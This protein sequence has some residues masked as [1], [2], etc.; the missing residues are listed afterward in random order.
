MQT[1]P[2]IAQFWRTASRGDWVAMGAIL[3]LAAIA[4]LWILTLP[5][6]SAAVFVAPAGM[7]AM[8]MHASQWPA[9][10]TLATFAM[11]T[12]MMG[13]MMLPAVAPI[14]LLH[15]RMATANRMQDAVAP[16][17]SLLTLGYASVWVGFALLA[18][19][20]Q[21]AL[22]HAALLNPAD[23]LANRRLA[24]GMLAIA[25]AYQFAPLKQSCLRLCRSP[26]S[27]LMRYYR[28]GSSGAL[29]MGLLHGTFCLGCCWA[30]MAL[31]FAGGVMNLLWIAGLS[32]FALAEKALPFGEAAG[33]VLGLAAMAAGF[34]LLIAG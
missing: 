12:I 31:L 34:Y 25:G 14:V 8:S 22:S 21:W 2:P 26:V 10:R 6:M 23:A 27:F 15:R 11:W 13:A 24:G 33:R 19:A 32:I 17:T 29:R 28:P 16:P 7:A 9:S 18:T 1:S 20:A 30:A 5:P 4:W 3:L